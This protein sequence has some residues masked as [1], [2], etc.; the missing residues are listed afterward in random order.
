MFLFPKIERVCPW[1]DR[2]DEAMDGDFCKMCKR[3]V[4]DMTG[5]DEA[6]QAAFLTACGGDACV[7]YTFRL[8]PAVAAAA[9]AAGTV[10]LLAP[11]SAM[12]Q[13][14]EPLPPHAMKEPP[15]PLYVTGGVP[16]PIEIPKAPEPPTP[17]EPP[18]EPVSDALTRPNT[19]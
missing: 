4:H 5:K 19:D 13:R 3:T 1:L 18:K 11:G 12:A 8:S 6:E 17:P 7:S 16:P 15:Y 10:A 14:H 2:L 9:L